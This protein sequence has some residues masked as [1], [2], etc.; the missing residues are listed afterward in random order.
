MAEKKTTP[1]PAPSQ[2][3]SAPSTN[4]LAVV[5][6]VAGIVGLTLIPFLASIAAVVTGHIGLKEIRA[7]G[8][9][10]EGMAVAGLITGYIGVGIGLV[11]WIII[12]FFFGALLSAGLYY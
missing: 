5:S 6:L 4:A 8:D 12:L 2:P 10:G 9:R 1:T 11:V 7:K 3:A